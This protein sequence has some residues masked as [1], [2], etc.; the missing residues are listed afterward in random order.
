MKFF[1]KKKITPHENENKIKVQEGN[2]KVDPAIQ[3]D[4]EESDE[5]KNEKKEKTNQ[6]NNIKNN[7]EIL[8]QIP[9]SNK[10]NKEIEQEE[11]ENEKD[12]DVDEDICNRCKEKLSEEWKKP[13][14]KWN[15]D[16]NIKFCVNCYKI[17]EIEYEK[18]MN[19]CIVC[20]SKLKFLR[21]NPRPEWKMKGQLCRKCWDSKNINYKNEK[22]KG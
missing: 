3:K 20:D 16:K 11:G 17:K 6:N 9:I 18:M 13:H 12:L 7:D 15:L 10:E 14:W 1:L 5:G 4:N 19:Y 21:Y 22:L 2:L 8:E